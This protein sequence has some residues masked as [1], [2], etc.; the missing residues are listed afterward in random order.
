VNVSDPLIRASVTFLG[1][2]EGGRLS[3]VRA[4]YMPHL[5][6]GDPA[7]R[8]ADLAED[9]RTLTESYLGVRVRG[10]D[11]TPLSLCQA[12]ALDLELIYAPEVDYSALQSGASFTVREGHIVVGYGQVLEGVK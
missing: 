6:V 3:P 4:G 11:K 10:H 9:G 7:K 5:V 8:V 1:P 2:G 12:H